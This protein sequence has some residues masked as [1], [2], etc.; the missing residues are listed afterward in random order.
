MIT[1][2]AF[3]VASRFVNLMEVKGTMD[4]PQILSMLRLDNTWPEHDEVPWCSAFVNY[5]CFVLGISRTKSLAAKSWLQIGTVI[6]LKD[7]RADS[8]V[9]ILTRE[10]GYHVGFYSSHDDT[11]VELLGGNQGDKV[12]LEKFPVSRIVGVRR[13]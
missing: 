11:Q 2:S 12:C 3:Q 4:S 5:V 7:A 1:T 8:D 6:E 9:V 10:G 13:L